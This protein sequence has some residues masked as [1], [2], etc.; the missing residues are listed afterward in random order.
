MFVLKKGGIP[1]IIENG[2]SGF[3]FDNISYKAIANQITE[4]VNEMDINK[5]N[6]IKKEAVARSKEFSIDNFTKLLDYYVLEIQS[7]EVD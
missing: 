4:F 2:V 5:M 7:K 6:M 1:E 3:L